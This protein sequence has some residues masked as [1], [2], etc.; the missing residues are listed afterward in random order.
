MDHTRP[1][2]GATTWLTEAIALIKQKPDL[3]AAMRTSDGF[4][5]R[6]VCKHSQNALPYPALAQRRKRFHT[7]F[8]LPKNSE[9]S[10][11]SVPSLHS[12]ATPLNPLTLSVGNRGE[13]MQTLI[14]IPSARLAAA[15]PQYKLPVGL[16]CA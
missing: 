15:S 11:H 14:R 8:H 5:I 16:D 13:A 2:D 12:G 3:M 4:E 6:I 1:H 7:L 9:S 10:R